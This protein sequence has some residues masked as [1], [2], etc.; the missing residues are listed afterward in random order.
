MK[1]IAIFNFF[2]TSILIVLGLIF[3]NWRA[4]FI[5]RKE[6]EF[7]TISITMCKISIM[8]FII[9]LNYSLFYGKINYIY[10]FL[11]I[12]KILCFVAL[13]LHLCKVIILKHLIIYDN[14]ILLKKHI[15]KLYVESNK[16]IIKTNNKTFHIDIDDK[17]NKK[18]LKNSNYITT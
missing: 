11:H 18:L 8:Y 1:F 16:L 6:S 13:L 4:F 3:I 12:C 9:S 7:T 17:S 2:S 5:P 10:I 14:D 15:N